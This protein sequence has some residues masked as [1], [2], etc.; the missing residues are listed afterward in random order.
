ML[1][2]ARAALAFLGRPA[3]FFFTAVFALA[4]LRLA[5]TFLTAF[6]AAFL[7]AFFTVF[8]AFLAIN[9]SSIQ[10]IPTTA[11]AYLAMAGAS[12]P[13][14]IIISSLFATICSTIAA[15]VAVK[16]LEKLKI[17]RPKTGGLS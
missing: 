9:T 2:T 14:L 7:T 1:S 10:I 16:L 17:F 13:S 15:V 4:G 12:H 6:L 8:T 3:A 5:V 11:I